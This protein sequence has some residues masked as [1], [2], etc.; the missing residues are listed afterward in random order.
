MTIRHILTAVLTIIPVAIVF[1]Q[2]L[3]AEVAHRGRPVP[4]VPIT[5]RQMNSPDNKDLMILETTRCTNTVI[6]EAIREDFHSSMYT[7]F[8]TV[9]GP[10]T[11]M[12]LCYIE[13][14][15]AGGLVVFV[16]YLHEG[17]TGMIQIPSNKFKKRTN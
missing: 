9:D 6:L 11:N 13:Y 2:E 7:G 1:A 12:P 8:A 17:R 4:V 16:H 3:E 10:G 5:D 14:M 15:R